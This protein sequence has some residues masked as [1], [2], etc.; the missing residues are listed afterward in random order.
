MKIDRS[1]E[2]S[3]RPLPAQTPESKGGVKR[4]QTGIL[5]AVETQMTRMEESWRHYVKDF[6]LQREIVQV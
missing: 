2:P 5:V 4:S 1:S 3:W 6:P